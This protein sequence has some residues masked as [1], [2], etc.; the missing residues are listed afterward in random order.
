[1]NASAQASPI[2]R[3][4]CDYDHLGLVLAARHRVGA[5]HIHDVL[6][7]ARARRLARGGR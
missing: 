6:Q 7:S 3:T 5:G 1:M 2:E 4:V